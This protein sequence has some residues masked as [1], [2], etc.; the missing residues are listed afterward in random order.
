MPAKPYR[1]YVWGKPLCDVATIG[2]AQEALMAMG[3][4]MPIGENCQFE[5]RRGKEVVLEGEM[6]ADPL[7]PA[8]G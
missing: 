4:R 6:S 7:P 5:V 8:E 1:V 3:H 2:E